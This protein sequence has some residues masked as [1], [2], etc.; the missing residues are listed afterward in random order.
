[1]PWK[2]WAVFKATWILNCVLVVVDFAWGRQIGLSLRLSEI[3]WVASRG[4]FGLLVAWGLVLVSVNLKL[5]GTARGRFYHDSAL[6]ILW[7]TSLA[8]FTCGATVLQ[9]LSVSL[10][11]PDISDVLISVD[12]TFGIHWPL[13]YSAIHSNGAL[14]MALG[15]AYDSLFLQM[16]LLP[17]VLI[18][19]GKVEHYAEF[20]VQ[21]MIAALIV[22]IIATP[23]PAESAFTHYHVSDVG[24]TASVSDFSDFRSGRM[25]ELSFG[26]MQGLVS[27]PSFHAVLA[28]LIPYAARRLKLLFL[29]FL[30]LNALMLASTPA[31]GGHYLTDVVGGLAVALVSI[32]MAAR[33]VARQSRNDLGL[34]IAAGNGSQAAS[35]V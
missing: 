21:F 5:S 26:T 14:E 18:I 1:M 19:A 22:V 35:D 7:I 23:F 8:A 33:F 28:V 30:P 11:A 13:I 27:F 2:T 31:R 9:Y 25:R 20:V 29:L 4:C 17:F 6:G 24:A 10:G 34:A 15:A 12:E 16:V 32:C 3:W